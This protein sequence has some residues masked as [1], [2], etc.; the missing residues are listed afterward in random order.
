MKQTATPPAGSPEP[1]A[2]TVALPRF[3]IHNWT[4]RDELEVSATEAHGNVP[5]LVM[6]HVTAGALHFQHSLSPVQA[7]QMAAQLMLCADA[8]VAAPYAVEC[9]ATI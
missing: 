3:T 4:Q 2:P 7:R 6:L 8:I 1:T 9:E 5:R